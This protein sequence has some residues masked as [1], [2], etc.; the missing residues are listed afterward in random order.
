VR[1]TATTYD[2]MVAD[3][4]MSWESQRLEEMKGGIK[5]PPKLTQE[6]MQSMVDKVKKGK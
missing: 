3:I 1:D 2:L 5:T 4:M 6:Q